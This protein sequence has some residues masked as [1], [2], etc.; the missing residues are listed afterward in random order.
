MAVS[1]IELRI[2]LWIYSCRYPAELVGR[3]VA[4]LD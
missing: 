3:R 1:S 2:E 4:K